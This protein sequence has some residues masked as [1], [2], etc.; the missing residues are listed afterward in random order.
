VVTGGTDFHGEAT[1][2]IE[3]GTGRGEGFFIPSELLEPIDTRLEH[4]RR[5]PAP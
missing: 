1:P 2:N 3:L 5:F 4:L